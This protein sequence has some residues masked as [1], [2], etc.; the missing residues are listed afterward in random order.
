M[1]KEIKLFT[2]A[3]K[4]NV[5]MNSFRT[6]LEK[7]NVPGADNIN[8]N[9]RVPVDVAL[10]L[11]QE[12]GKGMNKTQID[13]LITELQG[14]APKAEPTA[15]PAPAPEQ[16]ATP[17]KEEAPQ[18]A[19]EPSRRQGLKVVGKLAAD[20][21]IQKSEPAAPAP[22][23]EA[24]KAEVKPEPTPQP[25]PVAPAPKVEEALHPQYL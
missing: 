23:V 2:L 12:H 5:G 15:A 17:A 6:S 3:K 1:P 4:L 19:P 18:P 13:E 21:S 8:P 9:S 11:I 20:G 22:K 24:P 25:A 10:Q 7:R 16:P 14:G